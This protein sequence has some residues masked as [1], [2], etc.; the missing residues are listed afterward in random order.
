MTTYLEQIVEDFAEMANDMSPEA[1]EKL[2]RA[3]EERESGIP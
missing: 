2:K 3:L 1:I